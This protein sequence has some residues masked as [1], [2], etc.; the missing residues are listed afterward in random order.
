[1][2]VPRVPATNAVAATDGPPTRMAIKAAMAGPSSGGVTIP[3]PG[4]GRAIAQV[5]I[6]S[7]LAVLAGLLTHFGLYANLYGATVIAAGAGMTTARS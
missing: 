6:A 4:T 5:T 7:F 1:M 2:R 3:R